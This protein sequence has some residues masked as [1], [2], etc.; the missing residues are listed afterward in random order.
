LGKPANFDEIMIVDDS[1]MER[2]DLYQYYTEAMLDFYASNKRFP[3]P[4]S[5][6]R[7]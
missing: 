5:L 3:K 4:G 7:K 2:Y 1:K 6:V